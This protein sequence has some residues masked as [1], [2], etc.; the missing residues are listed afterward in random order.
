MGTHK[1]ISKIAMSMVVVIS[2]FATVVSTAAISAEKKSRAEWK[3]EYVRPSEIPFPKENPY[4]AAKADLGRTLFFDPRLSGA[5]YISC[6]LLYT[7][8]SPRDRG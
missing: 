5:N 7:S 8:P 1:K 3:K 4:T 2:G 6:C